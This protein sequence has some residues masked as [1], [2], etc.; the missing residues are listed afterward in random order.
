MA[1]RRRRIAHLPPQSRPIHLSPGSVSRHRRSPSAPRPTGRRRPLP[2]PQPQSQVRPSSSAGEPRSRSPPRTRQHPARPPPPQ[3]PRT[4]TPAS[5]TEAATDQRTPPSLSRQT[6]MVRPRTARAATP[7]ARMRSAADQEGMLT[8]SI[9]STAERQILPSQ[10]PARPPALAPSTSRVP[11]RSADR[12]ARLG[13]RRATLARIAQW[14]RATMLLRRDRP[15]R[16]ILACSIASP[17]PPA[18]LAPPIWA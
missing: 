11:R 1:A 7:A 10:V 3:R 9:C 2:A 18:G 6:R 14:M 12:L 13:G 16:W 4:A 8:L 17:A 15:T 5:R